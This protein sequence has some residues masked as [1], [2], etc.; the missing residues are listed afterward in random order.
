MNANY[1]VMPDSC[2][3]CGADIP[4]YLEAEYCGRCEGLDYGFMRA[5]DSND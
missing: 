3:N 2:Q 1:N 4:A 5:G